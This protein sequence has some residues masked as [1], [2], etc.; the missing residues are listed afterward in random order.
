MLVRN[1]G[2]I[3]GTIGGGSLE[4]Q[5]IEEAAV[6]MSTG[7]TKRVSYRLEEGQE[8][9]MVCG[10]TLEI[11][12]EPILATPTLFIFG[13]GHIALALA[14]MA[15]LVGFKIVI[16]D[17]RPEFAT[18]ERFP[19]AEQTLAIG[20]AG[21]FSKLS[22]NTSDCVVIITH[23]HEGDEVVLEGALNTDAKYIGMIGS[24]KKN[25]VVF[26]HLRSKGVSQEVLDKVYTPIGLKISAQ[27]PEE[28]AVSILAEII[29]VRRSVM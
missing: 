1:D 12:V 16:I 15:K 25:E 3:L 13:A 14:K 7:K 27:T 8:T 4:E 18:Q 21:A 5:A 26:A 10:G 9:G 6:A 2:S 17:D 28:I 22:V 20:Y 23:A 19:E 24:Q 29:Q 11:F